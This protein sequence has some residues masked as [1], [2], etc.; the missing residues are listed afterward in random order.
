MGWVRPGAASLTILEFNFR[1][2]LGCYAYPNV[3]NTYVDQRQRANNLNQRNGYLTT[4][5][6][7]HGVISNKQKIRPHI[8]KSDSGH[9]WHFLHIKKLGK[10]PQQGRSW[11]QQSIV[12]RHRL[13]RIKWS[14]I[15]NHLIGWSPQSRSRTQLICHRESGPIHACRFC[16]WIL[17]S[18]SGNVDGS[19]T[20]S[21]IGTISADPK[22]QM[23]IC[24]AIING[25]W[26]RVCSVS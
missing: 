24:R 8:C 14:Y 4:G 25:R 26:P 7:H 1:R 18:C 3:G 23:Q 22:C 5:Q 6:S 19:R 10:S 17:Y 12:S 9:F 15:H 16:D 11:N 21:H 20:T 13:L 2:N